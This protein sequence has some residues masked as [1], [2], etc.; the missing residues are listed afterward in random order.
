MILTM[1]RIVSVILAVLVWTMPMLAQ[2]DDFNPIL[3]PD[4]SASYVVSV[5]SDPIG[6]AVTTGFG[7]FHAGNTTA[8]SCEPDEG[9][10]F[11][12]WTLDGV[13]YGTDQSFTY[14]VEQKSVSF[15]AHLQAEEAHSLSVS[16]NLPNAAK[17][18]GEGD[19]FPRHKVSVECTPNKDYN[20][21]YWTLNG[22]IYSRALHF[23][24]TMEHANVEFVAVFTYT[25][26]Y[27]VSA[28]ADDDVAGTVSSVD[29][30]FL[31]GETVNLNATANNGYTF[32][33]W[34]LN[35]SYFTDENS[36]TYTVGTLNAA[37]VAVF[38][39]V[40]S[41]PQDPFLVLKSTVSLKSDPAEA[42]T[43]N[44]ASGNEYLE[45]E[46]IILRATLEKDY[47]FDG[48]YDGET[49]VSDSLDFTY[50]VGQK[51]VTLTLRAT[52][53]IYS[54]LNLVASP[55]DAIT[56]NYNSGKIYREQTEL[57]LHASVITGYDFQG[58]YLGDSLLTT[59]TTLQ[60]TIGTTAATLTARAKSN[61]ADDWMPLPPG[62]PDMETVNIV[63]QPVNSAM[64]KVY[65]SA[66]YVVGKEAVL[67]AVPA[68]GYDFSKWNDGVTD[69]VRTV[70]VTAEAIYTAYFTP[71]KYK[72]TVAANNDECT[73][74]V[75]DDSVAYRSSTILIASAAEG[76][77]FERWS[78]DNTETTHI[79][80]VTSD[81]T[82]T[83]IFKKIEPQPQTPTAVS[84]VSEQH[85]KSVVKII[86]NGQV[87]ILRNGKEYTI[88][89]VRVH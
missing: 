51:N 88:S 54:Q 68:Y 67:R 66:S 9:F 43:F 11:D 10:A 24:Y 20:F 17:M 73:A 79:V 62:D 13:R 14:T 22:E 44:I 12:Y 30:E 5:Y 80:Y 74:M 31:S 55:S 72:V 57:V 28:Q 47:I 52:P 46:K 85:E 56:F 27:A 65:G 38:D 36:F 83:A 59:T 63:A 34:M 41:Q 42:A 37:F 81:T 16:S 49:K 53:I 18:T 7:M 69:S 77:T 2:Q 19:Y 82:F 8:I 26:H 60:Y 89:G 6:N 29:A 35:G 25:P 48:W 23:D 84:S 76:Y 86:R 70:A 39:Y 64:G 87:I 78:D 15:V 32:S 4:P 50:E 40:P 75:S 21:Q 33:H 1:N 3:P 58:W 61:D 71:K 45:G